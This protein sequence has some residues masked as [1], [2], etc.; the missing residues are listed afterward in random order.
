MGCK[1]TLQHKEAGMK[2]VLGLGLVLAALAF[3]NAG[4]QSGEGTAAGSGWGTVAQAPGAWGGVKE[5]GSGSSQE[6]TTNSQPCLDPGTGAPADCGC[7]MYQWCETVPVVTQECQ[8]V[9]DD[10]ATLSWVCAVT[11]WHPVNGPVCASGYFVCQARE[12][13]VCQSATTY[14]QVCYNKCI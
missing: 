3:G 12:S 4:A 13:T 2:K 8:K 9:R 10:C 1:G 6:N 7:K 14:K 11:F 5:E